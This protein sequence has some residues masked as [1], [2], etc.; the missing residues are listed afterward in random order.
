M[1]ARA[2]ENKPF[3]MVKKQLELTMALVG[4]AFIKYCEQKRNSKNGEKVS[5]IKTA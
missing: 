5:G 3:E 1:L 4:D 2:I